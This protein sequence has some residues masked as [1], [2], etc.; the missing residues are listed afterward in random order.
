MLRVYFML[1]GQYLKTAME[2]KLNFWMM[3]VAGI[4]VRT[5]MMGVAFVLFQFMPTIAGFTEGEVYLIMALMFISEGICNIFFDGIW[6]LPALVHNGQFDM[7]L[8]RPVSPLYQLVSYE[9]GLQGVG[10]LVMGIVSLTLSAHYAGFLNFLNILLLIGFII[11]GALLRMSTYLVGVC[12]A[13]YSEHGGTQTM[14]YTMYSI[15]EY[16]K[17]PLIIY[18]GW[19]RGLLFSIIPF[20]FIGYVPV[21]ILRN[22]NALLLAVA[23]V[24]VTAV[25][26]VSARWFFYRGIRNYE[27]VGM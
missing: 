14:A 24:C 11:T 12:T 19:M 2:Y 8:T 6:H 25:Y 18:P 22:Q 13:F 21:L 16:A 1:K 26:L 4:V 23:L 15:G 5:L 27:S 3:F 20:G 10:V 17:Y 7:M 9:I